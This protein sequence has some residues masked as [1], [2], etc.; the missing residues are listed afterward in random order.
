MFTHIDLHVD[1]ETRFEPNGVGTGI[2]IKASDAAFPEVTIYIPDRE[3]KIRLAE[4]ILGEPIITR[5]EVRELRE[6]KEPYVP[7][8]LAREAGR[9]LERL[10]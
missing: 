10:K 7:D 3:T 1:A 4:A 9:R 8:V 5:D 2:V 6:M